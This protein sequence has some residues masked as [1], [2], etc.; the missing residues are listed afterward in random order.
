M[1]GL[2]LIERKEIKKTRK[3][4]LLDKTDILFGSLAFCSI[5]KL[6]RNLEELSEKEL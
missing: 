6:H 2:N 1:S 4:F 3:S 5:E